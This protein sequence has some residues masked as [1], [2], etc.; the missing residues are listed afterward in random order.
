MLISFLSEGFQLLSTDVPN[1]TKIFNFLGWLASLTVAASLVV[2]TDTHAKN[3]SVKIALAVS[4]T[5]AGETFGGPA[6]EG[7]RLAVEEANASGFSTHI[8][9][10]IHDDGSNAE[11]GRETVRKIAKD[12]AL[13]I[14]G[15]AT[16]PMAL[17][18]GPVCTEV[19]IVCIGT[20]TTGDTV[21][22]SAN[23]FRAVF[24]TSDVGETMA[25]YLHFVLGQKRSI[26][27]FS[28]D[29]YG[30][31]VA[32]G[33]KRAASRLRLD[34]QYRGFSGLADAEAAVRGV[35]AGER[36]PAIIMATLDATELLKALRRAGVSGPIIGTNTIAGE[37]FNSQFEKEPEELNRRGYFT[38]GVYATSPL[39]FDSANAETLEFAER[40]RARFGHDPSYITVQGYDAMRLAI[41]AVRASLNRTGET[42]DL[43][44]RRAAIRSFLISLDGPGRAIHGLSGPLWFAPDRGRLQPLRIGRF[45]D[46]RFESAPAQLVPVSNIG[47]SEIASKEVVDLG[48][49]RFARQQQVAYTGMYINSIRRLDMANSRFAAD[50]Y[51]WLR[52]A[53]EASKSGSDPADID[54]PDMVRAS[55]DGKRLVEQRDLADGT[56]YRLWHVRGDFK[57]DFDL[58]KYPAD[59][60]TLQIRFNNA[61]SASDRLVYV[62]DR[63]SQASKL[64]LD[65]PPE[66]KGLQAGSDKT[67]QT[68]YTQ[69]LVASMTDQ[70]AFRELT[71]WQP[72]RIS[73]RRDSMV[74]KSGLGDPDLIGLDR[75]RELS[76]FRATIELRRLVVPT[77]VKT[78]MP[79][80]VMILILYV[81]LH[82]PSN[83]NA[84]RGVAV[85][86]ALTG[87][88]LL[89]SINVQF[90][91]ITYVMAIEY[92]FFMYFLLCLLALAVNMTSERI[93][94]NGHPEVAQR[95]EKIGRHLFAFGVV[96]SMVATGWAA[97]GS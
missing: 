39:M 43:S 45:K 6:I 32:D 3:S 48:S 54:F 37:Y 27:I 79:L 76:G 62:Q 7:A 52:Y 10:S 91:N 14:V 87:I 41:T 83:L 23:I 71:Q 24:S 49:G 25:N 42:A 8:E 4:S 36:S 72:V 40:F 26:V 77:L 65:L 38:E 97:Y 84:Q 18:V 70:N 19:G 28:E 51:I 57:N 64:M 86:A 81:T 67:S 69:D 94:L 13:I 1:G 34:A 53:T 50:F 16:T 35:A 88:V 95:V 78:L 46:G 90:G 58:K 33:F 82:F 92:G 85:T 12:E 31:L 93:R 44:T 17:A 80:G 9:L 89:S 61:K 96:A 15:P 20:T 29:D 30:R 47:A 56:T 21:T 11:K 5:G 59:Y 60:Q 22:K 66:D 75:V 68:K 74:T 73:Q 55:P 2:A 63:Q